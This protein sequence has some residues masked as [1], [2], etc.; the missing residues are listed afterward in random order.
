MNSIQSKSPSQILNTIKEEV[1]D[2]SHEV[3]RTVAGAAAGVIENLGEII[4]EATEIAGGVWVGQEAADR[5][6]RAFAGEN[7]A[8]F[9]ASTSNTDRVLGTAVY[10]TAALAGAGLALH[11]AVGLAE[12]LASALEKKDE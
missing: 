7:V 1:E 8:G 4:P 6:L 12:D 11:G 3:P 5:A 10:G 9:K 2:T